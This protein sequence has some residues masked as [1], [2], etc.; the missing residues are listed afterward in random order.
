MWRSRADWSPENAERVWRRFPRT[1]TEQQSSVADVHINNKS[2]KSLKR[3]KVDNT[4]GKLEV[5][6]ERTGL[7][8]LGEI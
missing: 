5:P 3:L 1:V 7:T 2:V 6:D 4:G 8:R